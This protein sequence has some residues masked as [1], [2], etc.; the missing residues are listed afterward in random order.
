MN[1]TTRPGDDRRHLA[2]R[3][4]QEATEEN[5]FDSDN[6]TE[7]DAY[8]GPP[9][10]PRFTISVVA[11]MIGVHQQTLRHYERLGLVQPRRG[12]GKNGIR[13]YSP[14]DVERLTQIKR[15]LEDLHVNLAGVE[16]IL[17]MNRRITEVQRQMEQ[18]IEHMHGEYRQQ[19]ERYERE[20]ARL[21]DIIARSILR[22]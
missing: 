10:G 6:M 11:D 17:H 9:S 22:G 21:K 16:V 15:L 8:Q 3:A 13:Y 4:A 12:E 5:V 20:I 2:R 18:Q 19:I 1:K 7:T 14:E